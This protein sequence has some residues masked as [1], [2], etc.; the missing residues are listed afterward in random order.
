MHG[1]A[2]VTGSTNSTNFPA[3]HLLRLKPTAED[4]D[5]FVVKLD[6]DGSKL[7]YATRFGGTAGVAPKPGGFGGEAGNGIAVDS[8]GN[9]Y[10]IGMTDSPDFITVNPLQDKLAGPSDAFL[11]KLNPD[12]S[13]FLFSTFLG[14]SQDDGGGSIA[15]DREGNIYIAGGTNSKDF[16]L[17]GALQ[18]Y[19]SGQSSHSYNSFVAKLKPDGREIVYSTY[20]GG[21]FRDSVS[22]IAVDNEGSAVVVG[23]TQSRNFPVVNAFQNTLAYLLIN[24]S[25]AF[26]TQ[27]NPQGSALLFSTFLGAQGEDE[28]A[29]VALDRF[30]DIWIIGSTGYGDNCDFPVMRAIQPKRGGPTTNVFITKISS[31]P[32]HN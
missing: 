31:R 14:G 28:A 11:A 5:A 12:G 30:G 15:L 8:S 13:Q 1:N 18:T 25:D 9:A 4:W 20:L 10:V 27:I 6:A 3:S 17:K 16:P 32:I 2:Y 7:Q 26:I 22:S 19:Y 29:G 24:M 21:D 23:R